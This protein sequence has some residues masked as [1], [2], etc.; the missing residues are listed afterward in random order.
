VHRLLNRLVIQNV[1]GAEIDDDAVIGRRMLLT[2]Q[3]GVQILSY[4]VIG[5]ECIIRHKVTLSLADTK[6][7]TRVPCVGRRVQLG[8]GA[9]LL[10]QIHVGDDAKMART[11][12]S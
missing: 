8:T 11:R 5:D 6:G 1:Y 10:G 3:Q 12:W 2:H 4:S 9:G 7:P